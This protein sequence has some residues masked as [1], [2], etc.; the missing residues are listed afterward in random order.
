MSLKWSFHYNSSTICTVLVPTK[1]IIKY[2]NY[3]PKLLHLLLV[4][5]YDRVWRHNQLLMLR[6]KGYLLSTRIS[7]TCSKSMYARASASLVLV[8]AAK[9]KDK[10]IHS[11]SNVMR[12]IGVHMNR[13]SWLHS[14]SD[15]HHVIRER[16]R[17]RQH[18]IAIAIVFLWYNQS[19]AFNQEIK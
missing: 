16:R 1:R 10:Q 6:A 11:T 18:L 8:K 13:G 17:E 7:M 19:R 5:V 2:P 3:V 4:Y 15:S 12:Y 14:L 9:R